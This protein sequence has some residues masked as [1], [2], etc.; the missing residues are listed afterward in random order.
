MGWQERRAREKENVRSR[1]LDA[2]RELFEKEGYE[3]VTMR[4]IADKV[5]YTA[6]ALYSHFENKEALL[7]AL[8]DRDALALGERFRQL[9]KIPNPV[10]R[11][12]RM[13]E[14]YMRFALEHPHEYRLLFMM[15]QPPLS[16]ERSIIRKGDPDQDAYALLVTTVDEAVAA[17]LL[18][19]ELRDPEQIAQVLWAGVHG[20]ASLILTK[21]NDP[22]IP[23]RH[24][25]AT[26]RLMI[27]T[28][29]RGLLPSEH[30]PGTLSPRGGTK[31]K[32]RRAGALHRRNNE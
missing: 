29:I 2:A 1:I 4:R 12:R 19:S 23:W 21:E 3:A 5:E 10:E 8:S 13:G 28:L 6:T 20:F 11:I 14:A 26:A 17:G 27:D 30:R 16:P 9:R 25:D 22:W 32:T 24:S 15:P 31:T 7:Q 18:R